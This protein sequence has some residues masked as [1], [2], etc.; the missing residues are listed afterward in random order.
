MF[1]GVFIGIDASTN[2][3]VIHSDDVF[4]T[5]E[6]Y[7]D[8]TTNTYKIV[9]EGTRVNDFHTLDKTSIYT[10]AASALQEI[11]R[12]QQIQTSKI[13]DL[14]RRLALLESK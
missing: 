8:E 12:I 3:I 6:L 5:D 1:C 13:A 9:L 2:S 4:E 14:E 10:L 11:D 7:F